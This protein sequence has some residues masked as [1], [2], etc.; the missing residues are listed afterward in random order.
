[1]PAAAAG[2]EAV[3][4]A[5][6]FGLARGRWVVLVVVYL[7]EWRRRPRGERELPECLLRR[8]RGMY[9]TCE[10]LCSVLCCGV[11]C[12][13]VALHVCHHLFVVNS[14]ILAARK[15]REHLRVAKVVYFVFSYVI[16]IFFALLG[17]DF[18]S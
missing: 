12:S 4:T 2:L 10:V 6:A 7:P 13:I 1:M 3:E 9:C 14:L 17:G 5:V 11:L 18:G 8:C 16:A 15:S